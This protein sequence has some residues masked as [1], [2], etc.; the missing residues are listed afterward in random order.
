MLGFGKEHVGYRG[1]FAEERVVSL[2]FWVIEGVADVEVMKS[3]FGLQDVVSGEGEALEEDFASAI[4]CGEKDDSLVLVGEGY[5]ARL[6]EERGNE[7]TVSVFADVF[8]VTEKPHSK[9]LLYKG[10]L[11]LCAQFSRMQKFSGLKNCG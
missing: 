2:V 10:A 1:F 5:V 11:F 3:P 7:A 9:K 6:G 8:G 4:G